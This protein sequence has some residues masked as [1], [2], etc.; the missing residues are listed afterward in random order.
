MYGG[1][2]NI[3]VQKVLLGHGFDPLFNLMCEKM[4]HKLGIKK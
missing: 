1:F 3:S 2:L 4:K